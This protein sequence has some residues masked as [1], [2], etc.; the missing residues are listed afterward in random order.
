EVHRTEV[1]TRQYLALLSLLLLLGGFCLGLRLG[2]GL[3]LGFFLFAL[4]LRDLAIVGDERRVTCRTIE[5]R[6]T[7]ARLQVRR[8]HALRVR[9]LVLLLHAVPRIP[10]VVLAKT[11]FAAE[12]VRRVL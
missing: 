11:P 7:H 6:R 5:A 4:L 1:P 9:L 8:A 3:C 10:S 12:L 2:F